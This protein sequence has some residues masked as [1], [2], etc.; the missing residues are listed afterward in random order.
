V[1]RVVRS[2]GRPRGVPD[3]WGW[4]PTTLEA[5]GAAGAFIVA[6]VASLVAVVNAQR[7]RV[8]GQAERVTAWT[9]VDVSTAD[10]TGDGVELLAHLAN[11][12]GA[13][14]FDVRVGSTHVLGEGGA[15]VLV[16]RVL[17]PGRT[18]ALLGT[19]DRHDALGYPGRIDYL[20]FTDRAGR[21]WIRD[22]DGMRLRRHDRPVEIRRWARAVTGAHAARAARAARVAGR[23]S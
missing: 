10:E 9:E 2:S 15:H 4:N 23:R 6:A 14:V 18:A 5:V 17:A 13:P 16:L 20:Q 19:T 1:A 8:R 3:T 21:T 12:S 11:D 7:R 22:G